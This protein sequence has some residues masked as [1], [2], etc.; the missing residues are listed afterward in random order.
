MNSVQVFVPETL[1]RRSERVLVDLPDDLDVD[2]VPILAEESS[3]IL[4]T[5][6]DSVA[7]LAASPA[8][9]SHRVAPLTIASW[10]SRIPLSPD[11]RERQAMSD[12]DSGATTGAAATGG[13]NMLAWHPC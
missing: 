8:G 3:G 1:E 9:C 4:P 5:H 12:P 13:R 7:V 2:G 6:P 11:R 10:M